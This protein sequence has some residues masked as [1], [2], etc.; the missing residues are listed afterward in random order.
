MR[1]PP[2]KKPAQVTYPDRP[3]PKN[4]EP[5]KHKEMSRESP[6]AAVPPHLLPMRATS[7]EPFDDPSYRFEI[8][9]DGVRP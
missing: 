2:G 3:I 4:R 6:V 1:R 7:S 5:S 8:K 9:W